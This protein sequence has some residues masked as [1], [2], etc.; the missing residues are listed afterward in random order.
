MLRELLFKDR[1]C[2]QV[3]GIRLVRDSPRAR[4]EL[5]GQ[6]A[7]TQERKVVVFNQW[8]PMLRLAHWVTRDHLAREG[9]S[10]AFFTAEEGQKRR[11]QNIADFHDDPRVACSLRPMPVASASTCNG[12]RPPASTSSFPGTPL[13]SSSESA[14]SSPRAGSSNKHL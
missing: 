1:G 3:C 9:I 14:G 8:R 4:E 12:L 6:I 2:L 10:S 11:T 5:I 13:C 7:L